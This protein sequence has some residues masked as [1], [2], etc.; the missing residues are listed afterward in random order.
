MEPF[1]IKEKY[2]CPTKDGFFSAVQSC[3]RVKKVTQMSMSHFDAQYTLHTH[4]HACPLPEFYHSSPDSLYELVAILCVTDTIIIRVFSID[5]Y[6]IINKRWLLKIKAKIARHFGFVVE[7]NIPLFSEIKIYQWWCWL[8]LN[9]W[10]KVKFNA[11]HSL[12]I[13]TRTTKKNVRFFSTTCGKTTASILIVI[14]FRFL[15]F[16]RK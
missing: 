1:L 11:F 12:C 14:H 3:K 5:I 4:T 15:Y 7:V 6:T 9:G 16:A 13:H 10:T 8:S 2:F